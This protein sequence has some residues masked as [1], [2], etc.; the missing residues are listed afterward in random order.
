[1]I[2]CVLATIF[3]MGAVCIPFILIASLVAPL[4]L[5]LMDIAARVSVLAIPV[6][7]VAAVYLDIQRRAEEEE[8][9]REAAREAAR[10]AALEA[11]RIAHI[12]QERLRREHAVIAA[13]D[14]RRDQARRQAEAEEREAIPGAM[15]WFVRSMHA[16]VS[17]S[18]GASAG[19][20]GVYHYREFNANAAS[21]YLG[22]T[23]TASPAV[24]DSGTGG[25]CAVCCDRAA[26]TLLMPCKHLA[27]CGVSWLC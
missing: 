23:P 15:G 9:A 20:P 13:E 24:V 17:A 11:A 6:A 1:M 27:L 18:S 25:D 2:P 3:V 8:R 5:S 7:I 16:M 26:D 14:Y 19:P 21:P 10:K 22:V 12:E 4:I